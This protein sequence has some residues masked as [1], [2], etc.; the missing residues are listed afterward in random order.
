[1]NTVAN[2]EA[3]GLS[4]ETLQALTKKGFEEPTPIQALTI[5]LLLQ[6]TNDIIGQAQTGTG[7][8]AAFGLPIIERI[9]P[10]GGMVQAIIL[11]PTR[12]LAIQVAEE[13][14]SF[15]GNRHISI[16]PVYGGQAIEGQLRRLRR[17]VDIVVGTPGRIIDHLNR[18]SL[19]LNSI[20]HMVLDEADEML[21]MGFIEDIETIL[22]KTPYK[23]RMLLFSATMPAPI[24]KLASNYMR[25]HQIIKAP[26]AH[27]T[28]SA[29][30][31]IYFEVR[32]S[33]K[34]EALCRIID[35]EPEFYALVF[36][37]TRLQVDDLSQAL[38][39]RG[40]DA[41]G[42]HGE[43]SQAQRERTL[44]KFRNKKISILV[45]TDVAARG[46]DIVDLTH[47]LNYSL[48]QD[49]E[50]YIHRIGRTGRAGKEGTAI[51]FITPAEYR[52][53]LYIQRITKTEIRKEQ[54]PRIKDII[55]SKQEELINEVSK[56]IDEN[57]Y[58][59]NI[60]IANRLLADY[61]ADQV[62]AALIANAYEDAFSPEKYHKIGET[63][64]MSNRSDRRDRPDRHT[65]DVSGITRLFIALGKKDK[66]TPRKL[67]DLIRD[68]AMVESRLIRDVQIYDNFS[69]ANVPF[70]EAEQIIKVFSKRGRNNMPLVVK[71]KGEVKHSRRPR[72]KRYN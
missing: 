34:Y 28:V 7:K 13:M 48:P 5:P 22:S 45:A 72:T 33:D 46:I 54:L 51:T 39:D 35:L 25:N 32:A 12:E 15:R 37:R 31:Q 30:D 64:R 63:G 27:L 67:V 66:M 58:T 47:V 56:I 10:Q 14:S 42:L 11:T 53:L 26:S 70:A 59:E 29:T 19:D 60:D 68:T 69:F 36:C 57:T 2:F 6:D 40:Y 1:M 71:A 50:S 17:G 16:L 38:Q 24:L 4:T 44:D 18:G 9:T 20:T 65:P 49:P 23:K 55:K 8:T 3:L 21:N 43:I 62:V 41:A 61:P 52:K